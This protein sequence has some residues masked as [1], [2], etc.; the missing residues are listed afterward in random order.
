MAEHI[1]H[2]ARC[3][4]YTMEKI[5]LMCGAATVAPHPPKF[6]LDDKYADYRR[7]EKK[8]ELIIKKL[9]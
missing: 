4:V 9:Y 6:S 5:C 3:S 2:C 1:L 8:K 7:E